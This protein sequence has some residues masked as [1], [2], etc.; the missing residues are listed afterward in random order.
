MIY[1]H[2]QYRMYVYMCVSAHLPMPV[3]QA[4]VRSIH[5]THNRRTRLVETKRGVAACQ[6]FQRCTGVAEVIGLSCIVSREVHVALRLNH[7]EAPSNL[8]KRRHRHRCTLDRTGC[9]P[10]LQF[11]GR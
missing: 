5:I 6:H 10:M 4:S 3:T 7:P 11:A 1:I 8:P 2:M 9:Q